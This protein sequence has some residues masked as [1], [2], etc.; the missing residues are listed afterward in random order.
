[1]DIVK[2]YLCAL[3]YIANQQGYFVW[4]LGSGKG[5]SVLEM[6]KAFE[7]A[8]GNLVAYHIVEKRSGDIAICYADATKAL[9]ELGWSTKKLLK[10]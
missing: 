5:R 9:N 4:N 3:D 6:V 8:S 1:M 10:I 2:G 7:Q